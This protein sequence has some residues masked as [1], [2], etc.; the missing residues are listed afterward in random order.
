MILHRLYIGIPEGRTLSDDAKFAA[1]R[2]DG[3]TVTETTGIWK[4]STERSAVVE[5][6]DPRPGRVD[7]FVAWGKVEFQQKEILVVSHPVHGEIR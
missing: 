2:F 3:A 5:V 4:G 7:S 6:L 1:I